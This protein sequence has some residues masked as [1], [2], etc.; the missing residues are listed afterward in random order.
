M[1][2]MKTALALSA[3]LLF[4][5]GLPAC[6][7]FAVY[8]GQAWYGMNFDYPETTIGFRFLETGGKKRLIAVFGR[9]GYIA[10]MNDSGLFTNYQILEYGG[11]APQAAADGN[12]MGLGDFNLRAIAELSS[13]AEAMAFLGDRIL[14]RS[15]NLDL[16]SLLADPSGD[17]MV[18]EPFGPRNGIT[19][20]KDGFIVMTNFPNYDFRDADYRDVRG[21][22]DD[23]YIKAHEYIRGHKAGFGY[24]DAIETLKGTVQS[25]AYPTLV[26]IVFDP[27]RME[28]YF[29]L[30]RDFSRTWKI[31][32][33]DETLRKHPSSPFD[34]PVKLGSSVFWASEVLKKKPR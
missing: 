11:A 18:V 6:T 2:T 5:R 22:G 29:C 17:A 15:F 32:F 20:V 16:H 30:E 31:S 23:R 24:K 12:R 26:S 1:K 33:K 4:N 7:S 14:T 9:D 10:G 13:V 19:T 25:G 3:C 28:V 27:A 8:S 21:V 34:K